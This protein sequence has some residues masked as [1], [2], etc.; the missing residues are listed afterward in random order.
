LSGDYFLNWS[1]HEAN[2]SSTFNTFRETNQFSDVTLACDDH[3]QLEAH[4]VILSAAS[5]FLHNILQRNQH[6]HP[7]LYIRGSSKKNLSALLDFMYSGEASVQSEELE[8]FMKLANDFKVKGLFEEITDISKIGQ[9]QNEE[10]TTRDV[11]ETTDKELDNLE[12]D[13]IEIEDRNIST[14]NDSQEPPIVQETDDDLVFEENKDPA[15]VAILEKELSVL[16]YKVS[17]IV[18]RLPDDR[19]RCTECNYTSE[20]KGHVKEHAEDHIEI[21][22]ENVRRF[23]VTQL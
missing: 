1:K 5:P 11:D 6:A 17:K 23:L 21:D 20:Y 4:K 8:N 15:D 16:N 14:N 10:L 19:W 7:F 2:R 13:N 12:S 18:A 3:E 22:M 9:S